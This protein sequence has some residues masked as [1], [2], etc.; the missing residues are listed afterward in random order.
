[1]NS[2]PYLLSED[3]GEYERLLDQ[4]LRT[5]PERPG[6][7]AVGER[8]NTEQLRTMLLGATNRIV[9]AAATE[10]EYYVRVRKQHR[11]SATPSESSGAVSSS[12][13]SASGH[14]GS[15]NRATVRRDS[16][17]LGHRFGAALLGGGPP[18]GRRISDGVAPRRWA[19]MS[20]SRRLLAGLLGLR[21]R[22]EVPKAAG[23]R[24]PRTS[25][26][27][28]ARH[29]PLAEE[30]TGAGALAVAAVLAPLV[31]GTVA[32]ISL[33]VGYVLTMFNP[34]PSFASTMVAVGWWFAAITAAAVLVAVTGLVITA[35]RDGSTS[36][37][38]EE[39]VEDLQDDVSRAKEAWRQA[40]VERG[41]LP[42]LR[43]ELADPSAGPAQ[44]IPHRSPNRI[45]NLGY[46]SPGF[47]G[48]AGGP[49]PTYS[50]PDFTTPDFTTPGPGGA[51]PRSE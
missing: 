14:P 31:A 43:D 28:P 50:T 33:L 27:R 36:L 23:T 34:P 37:A 48:P 20:F 17:G 1:M 10:Y 6:L 12:S 16:A 9:P 21:V 41:I 47:P 32:V 38:A 30:A 39:Q 2:S 11:D 24:T 25:E 5:A 22:P 49:R 26:Q 29:E 44:H 13:R 15:G 51:E 35:L 3:R 40:L 8:L 45:P 42:F 18:G 4:V 7:Q 46:T 19:G